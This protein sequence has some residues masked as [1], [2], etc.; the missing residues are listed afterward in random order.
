MSGGEPQTDLMKI[1]CAQRAENQEE[2][3]DEA[4]VTDAIDD[5]RFLT[6]VTSRL[7]QEIKIRS[8]K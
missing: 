7:F 5:E 6:G 2:A 8:A 3:E 1:N 4:S